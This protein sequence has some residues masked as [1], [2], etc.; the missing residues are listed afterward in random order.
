MV[1]TAPPALHVPAADRA[2]A[3]R[4]ARWLAAQPPGTSGGAEADLVVALAAA[5]QPP[6]AHLA[7]LRRLAPGYARTPGAA[8][9]V[10]LAALA[11][12]ASPRCFARVDLVRRIDAGYADGVYGA[13]IW[14]D[15]LSVAALAGADE[16]VPP[17]AVRAL[18]R[19]RGAGGWGFSL[20]GGPDDADSTGLAL[21]ALRAAGVPAGDRDV[22][23]GASWLAAHRLP[24]AG[25]SGAVPGG[26]D[27]DSTS[28]AL[29]GL[30]AAGRTAPSSATAALRRL[31]GADGSF[32]A[33]ATAPGSLLLATNSAVPALL[34]AP[35]VLRP[36]ARPS[37]PCG[38]A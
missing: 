12:G 25:W 26:T 36:R 31:Q 30:A 2:A 33:T 23:A 9:K 18:R 8:A 21:L 19:L 4:G 7:A 29:R 11:A 38:G 1:V 3:V 17:A 10:A 6:G 27:A 5:G 35:L 34:R 24:Q 16:P 13:S 32:A 28:L 20:A 14:D 37:Q 15:A 22:R